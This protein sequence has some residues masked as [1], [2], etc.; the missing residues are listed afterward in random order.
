MIYQILK[1]QMYW[2]MVIM[3]R[4]PLHYNSMKMKKNTKL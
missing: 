2:G 1:L 4:E 3:A